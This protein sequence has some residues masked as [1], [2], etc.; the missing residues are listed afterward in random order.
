MNATVED[1]LKIKETVTKYVKGTCGVGDEGL[2]LE[3]EAFYEGATMNGWYSDGTMAPG[4][5]QALFDQ[6][7]VNAPC[8]DYV[9]NID[10]LDISDTVAVTRVIMTKMYPNPADNK[11]FEDFDVLMKFKDGNWKIISK[12]FSQL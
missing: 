1:I 5:I 11:T 12:A 3:K 2:A 10:I 9:Y 4:P 6:A 7:H 8:S